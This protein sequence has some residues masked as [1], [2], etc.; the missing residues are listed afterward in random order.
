MIRCY[1]FSDVS[2]SGA[3]SRCFPP[4]LTV[5]TKHSMH[6]P[7]HCQFI[8]RWRI[9]VQN[10]IVSFL[11]AVGWT[12][13]VH[14]VLKSCGPAALYLELKDRRMNC[15]LLVSLSS[16]IVLVFVHLCLFQI[17][18]PDRPMVQPT[19]PSDHPVLQIS[20]S[21]PLLLLTQSSD[22]TA[23]GAVGSS[24]GALLLFPFF[25]DLFL[26][27]LLLWLHPWDL[28]M[29]TRICLTKLLVPL[30]VLAWIIKIDSNKW[31]MWPCSLH[32]NS[33]ISSVGGPEEQCVKHS[34]DWR[35]NE[36]AEEKDGIG[37][38]Q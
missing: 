20:V 29:S 13:A 26:Y 19:R 3:T 2:S 15:Y 11:E 12:D 10:L 8:Q 6:W 21:R 32:T 33:Y 17:W 38:M 37:D 1:A 27:F 7:T 4:C 14:L 23:I 30:L 5:D 35:R 34:M 31:Q 18:W 16:D 9:S 22:A 28:D 24:S 25:Y 36:E